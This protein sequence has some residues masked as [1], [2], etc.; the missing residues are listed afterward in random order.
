MWDYFWEFMAND[1]GWVFWLLSAVFFCLSYVNYWYWRARFR[2]WNMAWGEIV[3][4][5]EDVT[6]PFGTYWPTIRLGGLFSRLRAPIV[7]FSAP[8]GTEMEASVRPT[9][10]GIDRWQVGD[11]LLIYWRESKP[12]IVWREGPTAAYALWV[13]QLVGAGILMFLAPFAIA[14]E[15]AP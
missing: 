2:R 9:A 1:F 5:E 11:W 4:F 10:Y 14:Y 7:R 15:N 8:D 3:A 13:A 12:D 6:G